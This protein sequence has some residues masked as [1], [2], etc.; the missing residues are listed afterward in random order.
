MKDGRHKELWQAI[1][2]MVQ[3]ER[4]T[5]RAKRDSACPATMVWLADALTRTHL[6]SLVRGLGLSVRPRSS[7]SSLARL[8]IEEIQR[9]ASS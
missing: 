3:T 9:C 5:R 2:V 1:V 4:F 6:E 8:L 7:K